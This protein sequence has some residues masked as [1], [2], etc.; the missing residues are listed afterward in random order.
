MFFIQGEE[1]KAHKAILIDQSVEL[2]SLINQ[3]EDGKDI[4]KAG[5]P[6]V[7]DEKY[8][9]ISPQAFEA[10]LRLMYYSEQDM[11]LLYS[12]QLFLFAHDFNLIKL[13]ALIEKI[14]STR[15][16]SV[17]NVL[18]LLDVAYNP[19]M[20]SNPDLQRKLKE[21]GIR[22]VIQNVDKI[23]F[24]PLQNMS[25]LIGTQ[26]LVQLQQVLAGNWRTMMQS[27]SSQQ[28][29]TL[30]PD[31]APHIGLTSTPSSQNIYTMKYKSDEDTSDYESKANK[32]DPKHTNKLRPK[33]VA[34]NRKEKKSHPQ[35]H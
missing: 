31:P 28:L 6:I 3:Q 5:G 34:Q 33:P 29:L 12:C 4:K 30:L 25:P 32:S 17:T 8:Y 14:I 20:A 1:V 24:V 26:I 22:F 2:T 9:N 18:A 21:A 27:A 11:D 13:S 16:A 15:E 7:L 23:D 35:E 10:M 19:L